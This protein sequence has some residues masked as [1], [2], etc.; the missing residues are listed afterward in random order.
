MPARI[1]RSARA[2]VEDQ[3]VVGDV[4]NGLDRRFRVGGEGLG[5]D[6]VDR[7]RELAGELRGDRPRFAGEIGLGQRFADAPAGGEDEG[8]GDASADDQRV[9]PLGQRP[10]DGQL[11]GDLGSRH[12]RDQRPRRCRERP[13]QRI[14]LRR[15]QR[16]RAG[17]R[18][19]TGDAV[20]R[21]LGAVRRAESV[22]DVDVAEL[23]HPP[24][25]RVVVLLLPLVDPAVLEQDEVAG[26][27]RIVPCAA[28]DP[29]ANQ[30]H[31]VPEEFPQPLRDRCERIL[32]LP[33]PFRRPAE[34]RG[35]HHG[36][37]ARE[38]IA[39]A[40]QR[41]ADARVV[42]DR[43]GIVLRDVEVGAYEHALAAHVDVG[44]A[45]EAHR[46]TSPPSARRSRRASG[47]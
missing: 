6:D 7:E 19:M 2:D 17:D 10:Q 36:A 12:D 26:C 9:D 21:R 44:E 16:A 1:P 20:R 34:V 23:R 38:R 25:E 22:V 29:V 32:G 37:P 14:E 40:R 4:G 28:V 30:R 27:E 41:R 11:G 47:C 39:D 45:P 46:V 33:F 24:R 43:A 8:V 42:G 15:H 5:A 3:V 18:R 31:V 35:D 13:R